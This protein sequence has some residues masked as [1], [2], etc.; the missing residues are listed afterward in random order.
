MVM[1][2]VALV[3]D[4]SE[5]LSSWTHTGLFYRLHAL[6]L[7][8]SDRLR[9][10]LLFLS[11]SLHTLVRVLTVTLRRGAD[12]LVTYL[13]AQCEV[14]VGRQGF[15]GGSRPPPDDSRT[16]G[17]CHPVIVEFLNLGMRRTDDVTLLV[18]WLGTLA[19]AY[20]TACLALRAWRNPSLRLAGIHMA[21]LGGVH[22]MGGLARDCLV[23]AAIAATAHVA[24]FPHALGL[25]RRRPP[26]TCQREELAQAVMQLNGRAMYPP[27]RRLTLLSSPN[28]TT[29]VFS[30]GVDEAVRNFM[31]S[32][33][34]GAVAAVVD[35]ATTAAL[36]ATGT[37][38]GATA[39]LTVDYLSPCKP[40]DTLRVRH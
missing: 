8:L 32:L 9:S 29:L 3:S 7:L 25:L 26:T 2:N 17:Y 14:G 40:S 37:F 34:G 6:S 30:L 16:T 20:V 1:D 38:P 5:F 27:P 11:S 15:G 22:H 33:H 21:L 28:S 35:V 10:L 18:A 19:L 23:V 39:S 13:R 12:L 31:S 24:L 36:M 4:L